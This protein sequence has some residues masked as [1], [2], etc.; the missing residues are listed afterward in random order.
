[1]SLWVLSS[2]APQP[3]SHWSEEDSSQVAPKLHRQGCVKNEPVQQR[4]GN[5]SLKN[6]LVFLG[7]QRETAYLL[8]SSWPASQHLRLYLE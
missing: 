4:E 5:T 1:M 2:H 3:L 6:A 7:V 8:A